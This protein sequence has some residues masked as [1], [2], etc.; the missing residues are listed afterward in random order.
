M[1]MAK[2]VIPDTAAI[3]MSIPP[4]AIVFASGRVTPS[5]QDGDV[6]SSDQLDVSVAA[7]PIC[8]LR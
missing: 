8:F 7:S 4:N 5:L 3:L 1:V 6:Y 2:A